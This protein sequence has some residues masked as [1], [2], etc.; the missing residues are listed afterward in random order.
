VKEV[1]LQ[2]EAV[3]TWMRL[4]P[5]VWPT[6][7]HG[8]TVT[9]LELEKLRGIKNI[10]RLG[11]LQHI[12]A[13]RMQL[14]RGEHPCQLETLYVDCT[15]SALKHA[16]PIDAKQ[17]VFEDGLVRLHMIRTYQPTFSAALIGHIEATLDDDAAKRQLCQPTHMTDTAEDYLRVMAV[18][19]RN[20]AAWNALPEL[21]SW[22]RACRLDGFGSTIAQ[23][24]KDDAPRREVLARLAAATAPALANLER[25]TAHAES[26][27]C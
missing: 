22:I 17:P 11:R 8:A 13:Q 6:M 2:M 4:D 15:A 20:Q 12:D 18:S 3:G 5:N 1:C 25:L 14:E 7:F 10:V 19:T 9:R 16:L 23:V 26:D 27:A 21:R 24:A